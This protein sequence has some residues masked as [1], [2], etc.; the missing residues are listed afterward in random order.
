M[1]KEILDELKALLT[2]AHAKEA[3][4]ERRL[5]SQTQRETDLAAG[6]ANLQKR[7]TE[8]ATKAAKYDQI[9]GF[10]DL[11]RRAR[12]LWQQ[13]QNDAE[14]VKQDRQTFESYKDG[15]LKK[16]A[17]ELTQIAEEWK[18]IRG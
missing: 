8:L 1:F 6:E 9:D 12:E 10:F 13:A 5:A 3:E 14:Q 16:I 11:E 4:L 17:A 15:E 18:K 2:R 7:I